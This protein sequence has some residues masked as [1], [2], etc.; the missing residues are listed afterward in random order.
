MILYLFI[1][2][3]AFLVSCLS[4]KLAKKYMSSKG[5][6]KNK[7]K[8][9]YILSFIVVY[10]IFTIPSAIRYDIGTDYSY[11]YLPMLNEMKRTGY[12]PDTDLIIKFFFILIN[13]FSLPNQTFFALTSMVMN[14]FFLLAIYQDKT[15]NY[16]L[17]IFVFF[18]N[19]IFFS[20]WSNIRQM[21]GIAFAI[22]GFAL[23]HNK[24]N[25]ES[26]AICFLMVVLSLFC[27]KS[28]LAF[29]PI[30][31]V[32][33]IKW[34]NKYLSLFALLVIALT[35]VLTPVTRNIITSFRYG[36]FFGG[37]TVSG[38]GLGNL[39]I[40]LPSIVLFLY[41]FYSVLIKEEKL[42]FNV[43]ITSAISICIFLFCFI[44]K[45][46]ELFLR[47]YHLLYA[48]DMIYLPLLVES[49]KKH[50]KFKEEVS[51]LN[52]NI[53]PY[54]Y[55]KSDNNI[56]C[57]INDISFFFYFS[58]IIGS[59][60]ISFVFQEIFNTYFGITKFQTFF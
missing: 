45:N 60:L 41:S 35:P 27:H 36:Y 7:Y 3:L 50:F 6:N 15:F 47:L 9:L 12:V 28:C 16:P 8:F 4:S 33:L 23:M 13:K 1:F 56:I 48:F 57:C 58:F 5:R 2:V 49:K 39:L 18:M 11:T 42:F 10:L 14:L 32:L 19:C 52:L 54:A 26:K 38:T 44:I 37:Y 46:T 30:Y 51:K 43:L 53:N 22:F 55:I 34:K 59:Y 40:V 21:M 31:I 25:K 29:I 20:S 24:R 17:G